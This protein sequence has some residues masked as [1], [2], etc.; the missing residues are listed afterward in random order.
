MSLLSAL[1]REPLAVGSRAPDF[2]ALDQDGNLVTL[3]SLLGRAVILVFYP[4]D[5]T[6]TCTTQ[7]CELRDRWQDLSERGIA[8]FGVNGRSAGSHEKFRRK[9]GFPFPLL[10]DKGGKVAATYNAG[11]LIIRRTV[12]GIDAGGMIRFAQRG[13]PLPAEILASLT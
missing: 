2:S 10:V 7:L 13:K 9:F 11:G 6:P 1:L 4:G 8:V 3:S 5:D 12:Y